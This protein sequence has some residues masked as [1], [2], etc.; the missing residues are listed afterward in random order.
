MKKFKRAPKKLLVQKKTIANLSGFEMIHVNAGRFVAPGN[1]V[2]SP[3]SPTYEGNEC[4]NPIF[5]NPIR[6]Q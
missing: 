2:N 3:P 4:E 5:D 1:K 6:K